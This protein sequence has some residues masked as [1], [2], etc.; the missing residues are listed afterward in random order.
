MRAGMKVGLHA[1]RP[2][3]PTPILNK[4][5]IL[6]HFFL[7]SSS[8]KTLETPFPCSCIRTSYGRTYRLQYALHIDV[9]VH[10]AGSTMFLV[11]GIAAINLIRDRDTNFLGRYAV[12]LGK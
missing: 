5:K 11:D 2:P 10:T 7:K 9:N 8:F 4:I 6:R 12:S 3:S 1:K